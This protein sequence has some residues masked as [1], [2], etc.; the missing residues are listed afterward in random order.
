MTKCVQSNAGKRLDYLTYITFRVYSNRQQSTQLAQYRNK[1]DV[2]LSTFH[3]KI[4]I[5]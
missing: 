4:D 5:L 3:K 2:S 1:A